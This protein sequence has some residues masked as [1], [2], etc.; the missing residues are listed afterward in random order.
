MPSPTF[1][2]Q[3]TRVVFFSGW[4]STRTLLRSFACHLG[5]M[6]IQTAHE[7]SSRFAKRPVVKLAHGNRFPWFVFGKLLGCPWK[8]SQLVRKLVHF[9]YLRDF[10][11]HVYRG[12]I[13]QLLSTG[14]TSQYSFVFMLP[15]NPGAPSTAS[16]LAESDRLKYRNAWMSRWVCSDQWLV[17]GL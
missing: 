9:T 4:C 11:T 2:L 6:I 15:S 7:C 8:W 5:N 12:E 1:F 10:F 17:N 14:R 13:T 3:T 16:R